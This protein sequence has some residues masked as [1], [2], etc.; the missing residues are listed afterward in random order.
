[1]FANISQHLLY[2]SFWQLGKQEN[3]QFTNG[4]SF[5]SLKLLDGLGSTV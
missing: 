5:Q 1:M 3:M 2:S 4:I